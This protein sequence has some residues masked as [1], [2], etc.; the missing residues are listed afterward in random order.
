MAIFLWSCL[1]TL[2]NKYGALEYL[3]NVSELGFFICPLW[4]THQ[5]HTIGS[6]QKK[7]NQKQ[8]C[9]AEKKKQKPS[10]FVNK[11]CPLWTQTFVMKYSAAFTCSDYYPEQKNKNFSFSFLHMR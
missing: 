5:T 11:P 1:C 3:S 4:H 2:F 7:T 8:N 6:K 10:S 9:S